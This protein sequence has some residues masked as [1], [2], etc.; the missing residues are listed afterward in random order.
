ML[1]NTSTPGGS[2]RLTLVAMCLAQGMILLDVTIVNV[3]LPSIQRDLHT[4]TG[5]LEWVVSAYALALAT[6]IPFGGALGD[7]FGRRRFFVVGLIVFTLA[8]SACALSTGAVELVAFRVLQG[9]GGA[10]MSALTL[11]ILVEAYPAERRAKAIGTWAGAAGLGFGLGPVVGGLLLGVADWSSIFWVNVPIGVCAIIIALR[12]V[13]ESKDTQPRRFDVVGV[14]LSATGLF[15]LTFGLTI[16]TSRGWRSPLVITM[17]VVGLGLLALFAGWERRTPQP[18]LPPALA[19]HRAF[20]AANLIYVLA[21]LSLTGMF[22]FVTLLFQDVRGWSALRTGLSWIP[23]NLPFL[24]VA[25]MAGSLAR[26]FSRLSIVVTGC[27]IGCLGVV[28][29]G[30]VTTTTAYWFVAICYVLLGFGYGLFIPAGSNIAM[31][32]I[33]AG[34]SGIASGAI[35]TSRQIG[36]SVGL[37]VLGSIGVTVTLHSWHGYSTS[38]SGSAADAT[39]AAAPLVTGGNVSAV[40]HQ[41]GPSAVPAATSSFMAGY[42]VAMTTAGAALLVAATVAVLGLRAEGSGAVPGEP[43][44]SSGAAVGSE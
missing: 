22:F 3:A 27:L 1:G 13:V 21:Y 6:L 41:V 4:T 8:S 30:Q 24:V 7:R 42:H 32:R 35:N 29:L 15:S 18:M 26:R 10:L 34:F 43:I 36:S 17:L 25:Q 11:S 2:R 12:G 28:G 44:P 23:M 5:N 33:P 14:A 40:A 31:N 19:R 37:A 39:S 9:V 16:T 38:L 20:V